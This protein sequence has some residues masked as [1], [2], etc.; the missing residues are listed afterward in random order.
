MVG[1]IS[2]GLHATVRLPKRVD[3]PAMQE[4]ALKRGAAFTFIRPHYHGQAPDESTMLL[5]YAR[6]NEAQIRAGMKAIAAAYHEA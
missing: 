3:E 4:R 5:S 1:G 6:L 2:A